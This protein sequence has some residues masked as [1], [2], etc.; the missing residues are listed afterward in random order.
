MKTFTIAPEDENL[1]FDKYVRK[2]LQNATLAHIYKLIRVGSITVNGKRVKQDHHLLKGDRVAFDLPDAELQE[3][4]QE[5]K[6][7]SAHITFTVLYEDADLLVLDK[8][9]GLAAQPGTGITQSLSEQILTYLK[10]TATSTFT[11]SAVHR[12]DRDTSGIVIV[13]KN[14]PAL[15]KLHEMIRDNHVQK[16]YTALVQGIL[17][18]KQGSFT[19][20]LKRVTDRFQH[21]SMMT[22]KN[23]PGAQVAVLHYRVLKEINGYSL[24]EVT[25]GTGRLHQI[26][27]QLS[28]HG[29]PVVGD[30]LYGNQTINTIFTK[31]FALKRQFLHASKVVFEHPA[32]KKTLEI[33]SM[34]PADL[35]K[36]IDK[37]F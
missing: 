6:S 31:R 12:L 15:L 17:T 35:Q 23:D 33:K 8:P 27:A 19:D 22:S 37:G 25:L 7:D 30:L 18:K 28:S 36:V 16:T 14:R 21:K 4:I 26:R 5:K 9:S 13:G 34:L 11:P 29:Y 1:R 10:S 24:L 3:F 32:T 20:Y 2:N